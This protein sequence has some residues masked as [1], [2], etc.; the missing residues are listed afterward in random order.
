MEKLELPPTQGPLHIRCE[1]KRR[2]GQEL[3]AETPGERQCKDVKQYSKRPSNR[4]T[5]DRSSPSGRAKTANLH[6]RGSNTRKIPG[7]SPSRRAKIQAN[8]TTQAPTTARSQD[9][10]RAAAHRD[11]RRTHRTSGRAGAGAR[12]SQIA[13]SIWDW[14]SKRLKECVF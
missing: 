6:E 8:C 1:L 12:V 2:I 3:R 13:D 14:L 10:A 7:S 4:Q 11:D 9:R 5:Q